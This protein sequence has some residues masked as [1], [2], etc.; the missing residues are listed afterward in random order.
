MSTTATGG[1]FGQITGVL[2]GLNGVLGSAGGVAETYKSNFDSEGRAIREEQSS[3]EVE[4]ANRRTVYVAGGAGLALAG[5][6][7]LAVTSGRKKTTTT[8]RKAK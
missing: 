7:A 1:I 8:R 6:A 4:K 2:D 3:A 5:I